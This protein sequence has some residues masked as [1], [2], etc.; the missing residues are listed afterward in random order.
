MNHLRVVPLFVL[1][2]ASAICFQAAGAVLDNFDEYVQGSGNT[3][4]IQGANTLP[5]AQQGT[6]GKWLRFG[7]A[8]SDG[9]YSSSGAGNGGTGRGV[10]ANASFGTSKTLYL[11]EFFLTTAQNLSISGTGSI[12]LDIKVTTTLLPNTMVAIEVQDAGGTQ[13]LSTAQSLAS[14]ST[15]QTF[16]FA[17]T[18]G[19]TTES[20]IGSPNDSL[21]TVLSAVTEI[22]LVFSDTVDTAAA[23]IDFDNLTAL[24][25][26]PEPSVG[27][28]LLGLLTG[29]GFLRGVKRF[30]SRD[31]GY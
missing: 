26:I 14:D 17:F 4:Y 10:V 20:L 16:T 6:N 15:Y 11:P 29:V 18:P 25:A 2:F 8:V 30:F 21:A 24:T 9:L 5:T 31:S 23:N 22:N 7:S 13:Y 27:M 28:L 3:T 19:T 12:S 1:F